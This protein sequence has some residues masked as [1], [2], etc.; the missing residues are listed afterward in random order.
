MVHVWFFIAL[1]RVLGVSS[2]V[3]TSTATIEIK[4]SMSY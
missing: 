4:K 1:N 2:T 3:D